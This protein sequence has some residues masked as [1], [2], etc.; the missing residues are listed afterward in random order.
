MRKEDLKDGMV[1]ET[2]RGDRYLIVKDATY[3]VKV[4]TYMDLITHNQDLTYSPDED[5]DIMKVFNPCI[6]SIETMLK[7]PG[8]PIWERKESKELTVEE[9]EKL[10]G[11]PI[12]VVK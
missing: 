3:A 11:Y 9:I 1:V 7:H 10:L 6:G 8:K 2:K 5:L 4:S 12:K